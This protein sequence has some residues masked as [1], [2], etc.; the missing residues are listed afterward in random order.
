M[1]VEVKDRRDVDKDNDATRFGSVLVG[2]AG[3]GLYGELDDDERVE[4]RSTDISRSA[5]CSH[6]GC[7]HAPP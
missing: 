2:H 1:D 4:R 5:G 7:R 3:R 6:L